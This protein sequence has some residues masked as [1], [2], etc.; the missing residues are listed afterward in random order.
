M[1]NRRF[2]KGITKGVV[3]SCLCVSMFSGCNKDGDV[4]SDRSTSDSATREN[5]SE[6]TVEV[7]LK[8][9]DK[10][11]P[12][13]LTSDSLI[14]QIKLKH[15]DEEENNYADAM[16]NLEKDHVFVYENLPEKFFDNESYDCFKVFYDADL[17]K[18]VSITVDTDYEDK[19]ATIA[20]CLTFD[21]NVEQSSTA[22]D[23]TWGTR[24]K[25]WLVRYVDLETGQMLDKPVVTVFTIRQELDTPTLTQSVD[26]QGYYSLSWT[27]VEG[28][29][30]Y[31]VYFLN[32]GMDYAELEFSADSNTF[33]CN[34]SDFKTAKRREERFKETY[35][36][37]EINV[38]DKW[39]MNEMLMEDSEYFVVAKTADGK[40]SG[41]SNCCETCKMFGELPFEVSDKYVTDYEGSSI[42]DL[43]AYVDV[44]MLDG[45]I[46]K[47]LIDYN[48]ATVHLLE[49]GSIS[50]WP[51]IKNLPIGMWNVSLKGVDYDDFMSN[52]DLLKDR[53][54]ELEGKNGKTTQNIDIPYVPGKDDVTGRDKKVTDEK[55]T[56]FELE[57]ELVKTVYANTSVG[58]WIAYNLLMHNE[59]ISLDEFPQAADTQMLL[60]AFLEAYNQNPLCGIISGVDYDYEKNALIVS[61]VMS[62][63]DTK[64]MQK[65]SLKAAKDIADEI[66]TKDMSD[67]E[68]E[69]A[70]NAYLYSNASYNEKIF[71]YIE[72]DGTINEKAV[73]EFSNSFTPYGVL[74]EKVG[75]CESYSEAF[76]LIAKQ[77]GLDAII[78]TGTMGGVNH[79]WNRVNIDSK[80]YTLDVTNN[81]CEY[82]PDCY[83]NISDEIAGVV[84]RQGN[85]AVADAYIEKF[86]AD[87]MENEYYTFNKLCAKDHDEAVSMLAGQ[88]KDS[89]MA[90]VRIDISTDENEVGTIASDVANSAKLK[91]AKYYYSAGVVSIVKG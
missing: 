21:Y 45:S 85:D 13:A 57:D 26:S 42:L 18:E 17:S 30:T 82:L 55:D 4:S 27:K 6:R 80:W 5:A 25:F 88:L 62:K 67:Y 83:F 7:S 49:D 15:A 3:A 90:A 12:V 2:L 14:T 22:D 20:P 71:D 28:A 47:Y 24:S 66:I 84:Y 46:S 61:Y 70:I 39:I 31:E 44:Q 77:A 65:E 38:D 68:K 1:K 60:D 16:Y 73:N 43:P 32:P 34:Y 58:E 10:D 52:T 75:V 72:S 35:G 74:V 37:T 8:D 51:A 36:N 76:L 78:E 23:G 11:I 40:A 48:G 33:A 86:I 63:E 53:Q 69:E 54:K 29:D 19:K 64:K 9:D 50:V 91:S 41:M 87:D 56:K 59:E 81:D 89:D 79:E